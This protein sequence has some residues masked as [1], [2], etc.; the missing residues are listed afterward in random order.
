MVLTRLFLNYS[1]LKSLL[2]HL[3][4]VAVSPAKPFLGNMFPRVSLNLR[5]SL[6]KLLLNTT[7]LRTSV[8][9]HGFKNLC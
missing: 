9:Y 8:K 3:P 5:K 2:S 4:I 6:S 7:G 1:E